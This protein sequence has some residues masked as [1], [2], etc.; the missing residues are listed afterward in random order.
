MLRLFVAAIKYNFII[1]CVNESA[2]QAV[3]HNHLQ[4]L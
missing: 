1:I 2:Q 4:I 3:F